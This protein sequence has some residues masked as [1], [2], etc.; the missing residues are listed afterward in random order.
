[1]PVNFVPQFQKL[2][3][4]FKLRFVIPHLFLGVFIHW[5]LPG[6]MFLLAPS[7]GRLFHALGCLWPLL[8]QLVQR[9]DL[10]VY[11]KYRKWD[12]DIFS[13]MFCCCCCRVCL[14]HFVLQEHWSIHTFSRGIHA[15]GTSTAFIAWVV[16]VA[17][18]A[19]YSYWWCCSSLEQLL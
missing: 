10:G 9:V 4:P 18:V 14:L 2:C 13:D 7:L 16:S 5:C 17:W 15:F 19:Q 11:S 1:M 6:V 3:T 12:G 8:E